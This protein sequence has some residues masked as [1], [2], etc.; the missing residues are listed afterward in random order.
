MKQLILHPLVFTLL[1]LASIVYFIISYQLISR[2]LKW[3]KIIEKIFIISSMLIIGGMTIKFTGRF[4]PQAFYVPGQRF[5][6]IL[7]ALSFYAPFFVLLLP[8]FRYTLRSYISALITFLKANPFFCIFILF[9]L[10]A[11][12]LSATPEHTFKA[13]IILLIVTVCFI[14]VGKQYS[15]KGLFDLL[16]WH[17][18]IALLL[19]LFFG[20]DSNWKGIYIHKNIFGFTMDLAAILLYL[21]SIRVPRYKALF[22]A[23]SALAV[24]CALQSNS[25]MA[26]VLLI[27]LIFLLVFLRFLRQLPPRLAFASMGIFLAIGISLVILISENAEYL[28]VEKL[29]KDMTLTGRTYIWREVI[30]A[31][32]KHPWFGYGYEGFWQFWRGLDNPALMLRF[33][34]FNGFMPEQSHN[35]YLEIALEVGWIGLALFIASLLISVYYG[36]LHLTRSQDPESVL[37][38]LIFTY[39]IM[40]NVTES[41]INYISMTWILYVF[42]AT[43]LSLN[44]LDKPSMNLNIQ[45]PIVRKSKLPFTRTS[46]RD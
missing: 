11:S 28:I 45:K 30:K 35:G 3:A 12:I 7:M 2:N 29:G 5:S 6:Y 20:R 17:H 24:F 26:K 27:I 22:L 15:M 1:V 43:R 19:S 23:L 8:R 41:G 42:M 10:I 21:Q 9:R 31:V 18:V 25:G 46:I 13:T 44:T 33:P 39:I 16:L 36:V 34:E 37:P 38:L 14:Y 4:H 40:T 32:N